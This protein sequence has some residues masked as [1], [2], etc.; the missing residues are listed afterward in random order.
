M[1]LSRAREATHVYVAPT[2][3]PADDDDCRAPSRSEDRSGARDLRLASD[4]ERSHQQHLAVD[5]TPIRRRESS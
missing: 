3:E 2:F 1:G 4:L 5:H